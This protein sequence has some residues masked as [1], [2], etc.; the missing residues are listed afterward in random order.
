MTSRRPTAYNAI[1]TASRVE[2]LH[3]LQTTP[4]QTVG[5]LVQAT[6]L[7]P[8]TV[9]EHLQRLVE[10]GF[11]ATETEKRT[12]RGRPRV[13]YRAVDG[14]RVS[15]PEHRRKV[16]AAVERGDLMRRVMPETAGAL[17]GQEQHQLDA[18]VEQLL[19]GGFDPVIDEDDLTID[20]TP[21]AHAADQA[22]T[23]ETLCDVHLSLMQGALS[24]A[25]GPLAVDGMRSTCD[26]QQCV[27]TLLR[28]RP[29]A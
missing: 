21:C 22:E 27:I 20:L 15:S 26:P 9:R 16:Q 7:H 24:E 2:I 12:V 14:V 11:V 19:D 3:L 4:H 8:N 5:E 17:T 13:L 28:R 1:S 18:L 29:D 25:G 23:R 6:A 10:R